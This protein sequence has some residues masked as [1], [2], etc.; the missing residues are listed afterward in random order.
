MMDKSA[1][2][3][4]GCNEGRERSCYKQ[5][6]QI[7]LRC[8]VTGGNGP[9]PPPSL[10]PSLVLHPKPKNEHPFAVLPTPN[11]ALDSLL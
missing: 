9:G 5:E 1:V 4:G 7:H 11:N 10:M 2:W 3:A 6:D 8:Q